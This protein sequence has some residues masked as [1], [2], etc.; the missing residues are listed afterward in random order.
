MTSN[1]IEFIIEEDTSS[2]FTKFMAPYKKTE[3]IPNELI[4]LVLSHYF[5]NHMILHLYKQNYNHMVIKVRLDNLLKAPISNW[6]HNRPPDSSRCPD[7]ARSIYSSKSPVDSMFYMSYN[8][9][10]QSFDVLDGIHRI[11]ALKIIQTEN[12][13]PTN[14][15]V[16][17]DFGGDNDADSWLFKNYII[18]NMRF[19][20]TIGELIQ[21]FQNLN[22]SNPVPNLYMRDPNKEKQTI[23]ENASKHY[24]ELYKLHFSSSS[25]PNSPNVNRDKF[26]NLLDSIYDKY[27]LNEESKHRL[28]ELMDGANTYVQTHIPSKSPLKAI[29]K[30]Q[31]TG[32]Y[33]FLF[34]LDKLAQII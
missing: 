8:N 10:T 9:V 6:K 26:I 18:V 24:Q 4:Q 20:S 1:E 23:I 31:E 28:I 27:E 22:S 11:T 34:R 5:K 7:I 33:M 29:T 32:C 16:P 30:C 14:M 13:K 15:M 19:N 2:T 25:N 3:F 21:S 12:F 17:C